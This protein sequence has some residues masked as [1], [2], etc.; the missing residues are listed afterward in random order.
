M[1]FFYA[2]KKCHEDFIEKK[3]GT[4]KLTFNFKFNENTYGVWFDYNLGKIYVSNDYD[5]NC[6]TLSCTL[7]DHTPNTM[8]LSAAKQYNGFKTFIKN[9]QLGNVYFESIKIKNTTRELIKN[10]AKI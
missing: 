6:M 7:N 10:I 9:Y 2:R 8:L 5:S 3:S 1:T 4:A